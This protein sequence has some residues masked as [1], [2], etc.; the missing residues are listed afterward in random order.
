MF[1]RRR[2]MTDRL[3]IENAHQH[4]DRLR[5]EAATHRSIGET[6]ESV[7]GRRARHEIASLARSIARSITRFADA[8][9]G[10]RTAA[11]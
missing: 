8:L 5:R 10:R 4:V 2:D 11:A 3:A 1:A 9:E 7:A 6:S